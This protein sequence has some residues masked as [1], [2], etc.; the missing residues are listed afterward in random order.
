MISVTFLPASE[1][2]ALA[3]GAPNRPAAI[4]AVAI[5]FMDFCIAI[6]IETRPASL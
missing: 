6:L 1:S 5:R 3:D 2:C 4:N